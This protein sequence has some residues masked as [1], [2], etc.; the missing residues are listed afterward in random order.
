MIYNVDELS[1]DFINKYTGLNIGNLLF[2]QGILELIDVNEYN[3]EDIYFVKN[4]EDIDYLIVNCANLIGNQD[5]NIQYTKNL[6]DRINKISNLNKNCKFIISSL[7]Q[8]MNGEDIELN[9]HLI[10]FIRLITKKCDSIIVRDELTKHYI[11]KYNSKCN[12]IVGSCPSLL[13]CN[14]TSDIQKNYDNLQIKIE[15]KEKI[16]ILFGMQYY[17]DDKYKNFFENIKYIFPNNELDIHILCQ[18]YYY[19]HKKLKDIKNVFYFN[20]LKTCFDNFKPDIYIGYRLHGCIL[21]LAYNIPSILVYHDKRTELLGKLLKI[22]TYDNC[23]KINISNLDFNNFC[24]K[25]TEIKN[26]YI[27]YFNEIGIKTINDNKHKFYF[28]DK[29]IRTNKKFEKINKFLKSFD[30][31]EGLDIDLLSYYYALW[32]K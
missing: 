31:N 16:K 8:Q 28:C 23:S 29:S 9:S 7:G 11:D 1:I 10:E 19:Q 17:E 27:N 32:F 18:T 2:R 24:L 15:K 20:N 22:P 6:I 3:I 26:I 25:Q 14:N 12:V 21:S 13:L 4:W 5:S 30:T